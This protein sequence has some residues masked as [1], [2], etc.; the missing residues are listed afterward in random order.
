MMGIGEEPFRTWLIPFISLIP[1]S[2]FSY[3]N[4]LRCSFRR[5]SSVVVLN[6]AVRS[7]ETEVRMVTHRELQR[8]NAR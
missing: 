6:W 2:R 4:D 3:T 8:A 7:Q 1:I 5:A